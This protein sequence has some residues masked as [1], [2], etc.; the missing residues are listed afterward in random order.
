MSTTA[1]ALDHA[2]RTASFDPADFPKP[3]GRE[4]EWRFTPLDRLGGLLDELHP[5]AAAL[6][7]EVAGAQGVSVAT[8]AMDDDR[9]AA[10]SA[11][12]DRA[13]ALAWSGCREALLVDIPADHEVAEPVHIRLSGAGTAAYGHIRIEAGRFSRAVVVLEHVGSARYTG[14]VEVDVADGAH[15]TLVSLQAWE[16]DAVHLAR[17]HAVVG[18]DAS[19][20][21]VVVTLGGAV[22]RL[23]PTV[24]YRAPGGDA[25]LLGVF[26]A[27]GG[28]HIEHRVFIHHDQPHCRSFVSYKGA[29]QGDGTHTV[30]IGDVLVRPLA[31][32]V[33]TY[34]TN[35]NLLLS[36][37][38]RADSVPNLE[39]E[40]GELIGAGH[41]SA[42]GR[43]DDDQ[44]FY[45]QSR[46]IPSAVA[47]ALVVR[48]FFA[49][50]VDRIG[51][52]QIGS[53]VLRAVDARLR[54]AG[55]AVAAEG[56]VPTGEIAEVVS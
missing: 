35:R 18:R 44:L 40:T 29:L 26:F 21:S 27:D 2:P 14:N 6:S 48:G 43:F 28:Q 8:I 47:K 30:W 23:L 41:A 17:Q 9:L 24:D 1:P 12:I 13:G 54:A 32:G 11:P 55:L 22:V 31:I 16:D 45:L 15:L 50:V 37:G 51:N 39:L 38:A 46:G 52:P 56:D 19:F 3:S 4:E 49:E 36:D 25:E 5:D 10:S 42:T 53:S 20:R 34:E 7:V 33:D